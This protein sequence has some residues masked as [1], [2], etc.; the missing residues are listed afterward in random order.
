MGQADNYHYLESWWVT[1]TGDNVSG[2]KMLSRA[3][4]SYSDVCHHECHLVIRVL[5][6]MSSARL[7]LNHIPVNRAN[8][9]TVVSVTLSHLQRNTQS[10]EICLWRDKEQN[11]DFYWT[12]YRWQGL[13]CHLSLSGIKS[14]FRLFYQPPKQLGRVSSD[15]KHLTSDLKYSSVQL[16]RQLLLCKAHKCF[17][18]KTLLCLIRKNWQLSL[19]LQIDALTSEIFSRKIDGHSETASTWQNVRHET[20]RC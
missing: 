3:T 15:M 17:K 19:V 13:S 5:S 12:Y 7:S 16:N 20:K 18:Q 10:T 11:S 1:L 6:V 4:L 2:V 8:H 14:W 9:I